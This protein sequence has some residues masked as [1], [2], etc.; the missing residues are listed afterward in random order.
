MLL[1]TPTEAP[2][3]RRKKSLITMCK[4]ALGPEHKNVPIINL[5][6][7]DRWGPL[8]GSEEEVGLRC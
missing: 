2:S 6:G 1:I 3:L 5:E 4:A 7:V 8:W